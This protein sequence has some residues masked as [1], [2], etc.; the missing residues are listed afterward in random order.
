[1]ELHPKYIVAFYC[2]GKSFT[3]V[4]AGHC[5]RHHGSAIRVG[6][7]NKCA[8]FYPAQQPRTAADL[9][10]VPAYVR[11]FHSSR[12]AGAFAGEE[13]RTGSFWRFRAALKKPLHS[14]ADAKK[15]LA[16]R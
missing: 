10:L 5:F 15:W 7:I 13:R 11:R 8:A 9:N 14:H 16:G 3:I 12:E 1:M 6:V 4:R 2:G